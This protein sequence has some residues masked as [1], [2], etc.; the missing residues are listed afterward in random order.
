MSMKQLLLLKG[1]FQG[2][3]WE[4]IRQKHKIKHIKQQLRSKP[5]IAF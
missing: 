5:S 1:L 2:E 3:S 4:E